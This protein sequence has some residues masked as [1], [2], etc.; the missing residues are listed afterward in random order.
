VDRA[1]RQAALEGL[2]LNRGTFKDS[3]GGAPGCC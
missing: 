2:Y 1:L 3:H